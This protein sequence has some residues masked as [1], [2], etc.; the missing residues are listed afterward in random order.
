M[1]IYVASSWANVDQNIVVKALQSEGFDVYDF[2]EPTFEGK[3]FKWSQILEKFDHDK[4]LSPFTDFM[5]AL[6]DPIVEKT[7]DADWEAM[8]R[9]DACV[10]V[11]PCGNSAHL[12]FGYF[13]GAHKPCII[14]I[15]NQFK[16]E[17]NV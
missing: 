16:V 13:V 3:D 10:M 17:T 15:S 2:R 5:V 11:L 9:S 7:F 1:K 12:E 8:E 14:Y 6:N 4:Q